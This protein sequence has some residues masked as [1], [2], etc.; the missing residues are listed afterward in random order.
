MACPMGLSLPSR[1]WLKAAL[2]AD[3][4]RAVRP[5]SGASGSKEAT[6]SDTLA[7]I[8]KLLAGWAAALTAQASALAYIN[9]A[10]RQ[11]TKCKSTSLVDVHDSVSGLCSIRWVHLDTV[12]VAANRMGT[13]HGRFVDVD[14]A[15]RLVYSG[16]SSRQRAHPTVLSMC[17]WGALPSFP[18]FLQ[19][20][21]PAV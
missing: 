5:P 2:N 10:E 11:T 7:Q 9:N 14:G 6:R 15:N 20:G 12:D 4:Q 18:T 8:T 21:A 1:L 13:L 19:A 17:S 16:P 3:L